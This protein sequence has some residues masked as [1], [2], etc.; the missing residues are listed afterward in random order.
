LTLLRSNRSAKKSCCTASALTAQKHASKGAGLPFHPPPG[1][2]QE[3]QKQLSPSRLGSGC[4]RL[5]SRAPLQGRKDKYILNLNRVTL[6]GYTGA[7]AKT[8]PNGPTTLSLATNVSWT[9]EQ[10]NERQNGT[11]WHLLVVWNDLGKWAATLPKGT[12]LF[13]EGELIYD[14]YQKTWMPSLTR[15]PFRRRSQPA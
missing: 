4:Q 14:E 8:F 13:V 9:D 6:I 2:I 15:R 7:D 10:K 1:V 5:A 11:A 12:P 3:S